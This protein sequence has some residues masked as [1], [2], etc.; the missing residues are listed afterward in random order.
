MAMAAL[1]KVSEAKQYISALYRY[2][3]QF[4]IGL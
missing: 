1:V 2:C 4:G 3:G